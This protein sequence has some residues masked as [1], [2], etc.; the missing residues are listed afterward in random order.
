M[1]DTDTTEYYTII[2]Y[3]TGEKVYRG[4]SLTIAAE[5]LKP[6]TVYGVGTAQAGATLDA[7]AK[8]KEL[9]RQSNAVR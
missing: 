8:V 9:R 7:Q 6:G 5:R 1:T 3:H 2:D 4:T